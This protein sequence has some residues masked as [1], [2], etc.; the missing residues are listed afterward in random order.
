VELEVAGEEWRVG[1]RALVGQGPGSRV[2]DRRRDLPVVEQ[3]GVGEEA[4]LA[5]QL[6]V[7]ERAVRLPVLGVPLARDVADAAVV[8][9]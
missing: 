2:D 6:L 4:L 8:R 1:G 9:H 7:V 5:H 3:R